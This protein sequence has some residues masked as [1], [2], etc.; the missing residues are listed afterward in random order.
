MNKMNFQQL[1]SLHY[2]EMK[3][4]ID[5]LEA[6]SKSRIGFSSDRIHNFVGLR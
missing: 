3:A 1:L 5:I 4:H 2:K 6:Q